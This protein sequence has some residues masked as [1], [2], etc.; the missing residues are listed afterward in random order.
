[1]LV[2]DMRVQWQPIFYRMVYMTFT[3]QVGSDHITMT[4]RHMFDTSQQKITSR[5]IVILYLNPNRRHP[6]PG[7]SNII[8]YETEVVA[9]VEP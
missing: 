4:N 7:C 5:L 3:E 1:M 9:R 8:K 6:W 2:V